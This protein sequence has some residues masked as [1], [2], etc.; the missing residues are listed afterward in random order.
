[1]MTTTTLTLLVL[2]AAII[3]GIATVLTITDDNSGD[4][5]MAKSKL[6]LKLRPGC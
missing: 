4:R 3:S 6:G 5:N 2:I 1:M